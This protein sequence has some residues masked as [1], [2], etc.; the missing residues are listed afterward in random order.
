VAYSLVPRQ[1]QMQRQRLRDEEVVVYGAQIVH[2]TVPRGTEWAMDH[3]LRCV[4]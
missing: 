1:M 3:A 4:A 2:R